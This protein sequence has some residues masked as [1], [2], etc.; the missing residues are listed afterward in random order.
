MGSVDVATRKKQREK[1]EEKKRG[2]EGLVQ[3]FD[4]SLLAIVIFLM[5]FGL[6]M[7]YSTSSYS[8]QIKYGDSMYFFKRQAV[9]SLA[10][11]LIMLVVAKINYHW[12][13]KRS[14]VFY[15]IAFILMALVLTP[16]GIEVY[17]A[18]RWI[19]LPL[20]QQMQPSEVMK[21]AI[22]LFIP[23]LICQAGSK[24]KRPKEALKIFAW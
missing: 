17:G 18:R 19:R 5:C 23:Y 2:K 3:Y 7:L 14:K 11:V 13:A 8:A 16:L 12:Y 9:I 6:V 10:S 20:D 1:R 15:I 22:I 4:Y 21:I 24:V